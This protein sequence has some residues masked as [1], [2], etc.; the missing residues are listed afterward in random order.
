MNAEANQEKVRVGLL[1][2]GL[3][4]SAMADRLLDRGIEVIAWD[5]DSEHLRALEERGA[6]LAQRPSNVVMGAEVV[7]A[8]LP[9]API[10]L[11][12]VGPLL[13]DW[14]EGTVWLQ[15]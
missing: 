5:R 8:M 7:I 14:P 9:S 6:E 10:V 15:M 13:A 2:V 4:G 11:D 3:R 1:G 12:V